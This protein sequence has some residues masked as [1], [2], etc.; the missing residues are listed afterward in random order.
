MGRKHSYQYIQHPLNETW[1]ETLIS[2]HGDMGRN[3]HINTYSLMRHGEKT[4]N[5]TWGENTH[6]NTYSTPLMRHGEKHSYQ[7][8]QH[9][10]NETWGETLISIHTAPP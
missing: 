10:L 3:T 6:I 1:G 2:I 5:E 8:I 7:Y 9:P 4:L